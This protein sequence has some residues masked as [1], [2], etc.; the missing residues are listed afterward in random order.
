MCAQAFI[1]GNTRR[2]PGHDFQRH[3]VYVQLAGRGK[4]LL[5]TGG[6][7]PGKTGFAAAPGRAA[8]RR[9]LQLFSAHLLPQAAQPGLHMQAP[10]DL[11][12]MD[13]VQTAVEFD[14]D[15]L[16]TQVQCLVVPHALVNIDPGTQPAAA[17]Q[18]LCRARVLEVNRHAADIYLR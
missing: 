1:H 8:S 18:Q 10:G 9:D 13:V 14:P 15:I 11:L 4:R 7:P 6:M 12:Q 17:R 2:H 5:R 16:Q 3:I